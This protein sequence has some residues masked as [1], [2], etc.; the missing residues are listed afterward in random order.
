[1]KNPQSVNA[2]KPL[3][4]SCRNNI[5]SNLLC[6]TSKA[7]PQDAQLARKMLQK[8]DNNWKE[9]ENLELFQI[10]SRLKQFLP[11]KNPEI[12]IRGMNRFSS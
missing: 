4:N 5:K 10:N 6:F 3:P 1:M 11:S 12:G 7:T 9:Q 8:Y 2:N